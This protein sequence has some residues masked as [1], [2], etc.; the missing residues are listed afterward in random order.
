MEGD[1]SY[2]TEYIVVNSWLI[3]EETARIRL[4]L[5]RHERQDREEW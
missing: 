5:N 2:H 4:R 3:E 1:F